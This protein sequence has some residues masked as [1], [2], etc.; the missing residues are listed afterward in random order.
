M[1][2]DYQKMQIP[3]EGRDGKH[4]VMEVN[5]SK[6]KEVAGCKLIK[7]IYPNGDTAVVKRE[8]LNQV[9]F[10]LGNPEDQRRL[11]PQKVETVHWRPMRLSIKAEKDIRKGEEIV[12][13][14]VM[15][16]VPCTYVKEIMGAE[17]FDREVAKSKEPHT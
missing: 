8:H 1:I 15:I 2:Q 9:L 7:L 13:P 16:S 12:L 10:A 6:K 14:R 11:I 5:W 17:A 3:D 4:L